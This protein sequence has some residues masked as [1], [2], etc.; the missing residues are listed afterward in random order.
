MNTIVWW[1]LTLP[2]TLRVVRYILVINALISAFYGF[3]P[4]L[5]FGFEGIMGIFLQQHPWAQ[6][7]DQYTRMGLG[8]IMAREALFGGSTETVV[9]KIITRLM[10]LF[11]SIR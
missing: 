1:L 5:Y 8:V 7:M 10:P 11:G 6:S 9:V 3:F 4:L 2:R